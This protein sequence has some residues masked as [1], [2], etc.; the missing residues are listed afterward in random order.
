MHPQKKRL[1]GYVTTV[2]I[3]FTLALLVGYTAIG[4]QVDA[5]AYDWMFRLHPPHTDK[6]RS[7]MVT[8]DEQT[9]AKLGGIRRIRAIL[10]E[11]LEYLASASPKVVAVDLT[12]VDTGDPQDDQRLEEAMRRTRCL[13]LA[14]EMSPG[15]KDWQDPL[16]R[17]RKWAAAV[18]HVHAAPD[19]YN[20]IVQQVPLEKAI[21][22]RRYW[23]LALE[24][25]RLSL[26]EQ[27]IV[28]S[29]DDLQVGGITIPAKRGDA[30]S[31]YV[32]YLPAGLDGATSI[33]RVSVA[34]LHA[35]PALAKHF[36]EKVIFVGVTAQSAARDRLMTP[37]SAGQPLPGVEIHANTFET[38]AGGRFLTR[39]SNT[40]VFLVSGLLATGASLIFAFLW[41]WPAYTMAGV[42]LAVAQA[43]PHIFFLQDIVFPYTAP[44]AAAWLTVV[45]A[46]GYQH[47]VVRRQL[48]LAEAEKTRYQQ[49]VHFV[50]HE[51]RT[52]LTA[53]QGSSELMRRYPLNEEKRR[54][55]AELIHSE[56]RRLA[57]MVETFLNVE[58]L[59]AGQME[60][61]REPYHPAELVKICVERAQPLAA[62]KAIRIVLGP[63]PDDQIV[64]DRELMEYAVYNLLTNAIKYSPAETEVRISAWRRGEYLHLAVKDQGIGMDE[65]EVRNV[66]QKFYRTRSAVASGEAGTGIGLSIVEQIV[67]HHGGR[68]E[69]ESSP[70]K[71]S[72]FTL[73]LPAPVSAGA[74]E[75]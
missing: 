25:L 68:I 50:T 53:I 37:C 22:Q 71:G 42:L 4:R 2:G 43:T 44:I 45:S 73:V 32:R 41:G 38:L 47:L 49:A 31:V 56:S 17:F 30:R 29:P 39:A 6:A 18:G 8:I 27:P 55:I 60:L 72:C 5:D 52:P 15:G 57:R 10:A 36:R 35:E 62:R 28:E 65:E 23:A 75:K 11:A 1:A 58:R 20:G 33:P 54:Q 74:R 16:P 26:G 40:S 63:L 24:A 3:A 61:R 14:A 7:A 13:V 19:E 69:V 21:G 51:M 67:T 59:S 66:F 9:F 70:G 48:R 34:Q 12:L 46:A 64:G